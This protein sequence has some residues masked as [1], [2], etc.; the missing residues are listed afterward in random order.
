[1]RCVAWN[2]RGVGSR[3]KFIAIKNIIT[4]KQLH[5]CGLVETKHKS[6]LERSIRGWWNNG[7]VIFL[8]VKSVDR[9]GGLLLMWDADILKQTSG[10]CGDRWI[11]LSVLSPEERL[12]QQNRSTSMDDFENWVQDM[13]LIA[14]PLIERKFTWVNCRVANQIDKA[15]INCSWLTHFPNTKLWPLPKLVSDH[16]PLLV[17]CDKIKGVIRPFRSMDAW[18]HCPGFKDLIKSE[19][20]NMGDAPFHEKMKEIVGPIRKWNRNV[21][22]D[23]NVRTEELIL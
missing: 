3:G 17:E 21:F 8:D 10:I 5:I 20:E 15:F 12:G 16:Y 9:G 1:M 4:E 19:W 2:V 6:S 7:N 23:I 11:L 14:L 18:L 13:E 22:G